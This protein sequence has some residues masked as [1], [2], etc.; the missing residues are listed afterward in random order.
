[1][2]RSV[3]DMDIEGKKVLIRCDF[4]VPLDDFLNIT[5]DRRIKS[6]VPTIKYCLDHNCSVILASHLGRPGGVFESKLSLTPVQKRLS[7]LLVPS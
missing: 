6:A 2:V 3:R 7:R 4:N 1:M 5:D